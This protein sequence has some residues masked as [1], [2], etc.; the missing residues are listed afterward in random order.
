MT[1]LFSNLFEPFSLQTQLIGDAKNGIPS[2]AISTM[3]D[4]GRESRDGR[5]SVHSRQS[6]MMGGGPPGG[7]SR[8]GTPS[9]EVE[10]LGR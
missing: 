3:S 1:A 9:F 4:D 8:L 2:V 7:G 10:R 5:E 6:S